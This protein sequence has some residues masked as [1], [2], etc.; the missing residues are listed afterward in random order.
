MP[1]DLSPA[2]PAIANPGF[3]SNT[4]L[5]G[6][7]D[8][9]VAN[10]GNGTVVRMQHDGTVVAVQ[11]LEVPGLEPL[12]AGHLNLMDL[13]AAES[14]NKVH[15]PLRVTAR[16]LGCRVVAGRQHSAATARGDASGVARGKAGRGA[17]EE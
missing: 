14:E 4:T 3:S 16:L 5:A 10:R 7:A 2:V 8:L 12:G 13:P 1:V 6:V 11:Q 17:S 9:Y 15:F